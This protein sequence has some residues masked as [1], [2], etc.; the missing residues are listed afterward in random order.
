MN[1]LQISLIYLGQFKAQLSGQFFNPLS[2]NSLYA[3][4]QD[5]GGDYPTNY[6]LAFP[7]ST[8]QYMMTNSFLGDSF[9]DLENI[10]TSLNNNNFF[11]LCTRTNFGSNRNIKH[12]S[13]VKK[14]FKKNIFGFGRSNNIVS[15]QKATGKSFVQMM[16]QATQPYREY[17][18]VRTLVSDKPSFEDKDPLYAYNLYNENSRNTLYYAGDYTF[19]TEF[20]SKTCSKDVYEYTTTQAEYTKYMPKKY[21]N[22]VNNYTHLDLGQQVYVLSSYWSKDAIYFLKYQYNGS[23]EFRSFYRN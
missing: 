23:I 22:S 6:F 10:E 5:V 3:T 19:Q 16:D 7:Q 17:Q 2:V 18:Y 13:I 20:Q 1:L 4:R 21:T 9:Y 8:E 14:E 15:L 11:T 12:A